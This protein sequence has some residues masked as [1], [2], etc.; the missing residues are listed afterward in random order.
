MTYATVLKVD[1]SDL[2]LRPGM[3]ATANITA[4]KVTNALLVPNAALRFTPT[5]KKQKA[6]SR[7]ASL[8]NQLLLRRPRRQPASQKHEDAKGTKEQKHVWVLRNG[9]PVPVPVRVGATNGIMT[10]VKSDS[11]E[12]GMALVLSTIKEN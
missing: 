8:V 7:G 6:A 10:E 9:Q 2:F 5:V 4:E 1:N 11:I 3:T 12:P